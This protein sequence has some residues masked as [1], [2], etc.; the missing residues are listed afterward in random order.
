M[1]GLARVFIVDRK[2]VMRAFEINKR[3]EVRK[4]LRGG[5]F[6]LE[7]INRRKNKAGIKLNNCQCCSSLSR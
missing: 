7:R 4:S 1:D 2:H 3:N 6:Q 5:R